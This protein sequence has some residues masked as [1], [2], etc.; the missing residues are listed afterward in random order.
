MIV[1][2]MVAS[3]QKGDRECHIVVLMDEDVVDWDEQY[4]P[5]M[6]ED[7]YAKSKISPVCSSPFLCPRAASACLLPS[8]IP[9][10]SF[11]FLRFAGVTSTELY[12][13]FKYVEN[14]EVAKQVSSH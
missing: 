1:P 3:A 6:A 11:F 7:H 12:R 5:Q 8:C 4:P 14:R 10:P 2:E 13:F 9:R